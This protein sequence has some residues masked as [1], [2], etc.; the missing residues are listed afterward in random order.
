MMRVAVLG[1][2]GVGG[3]VAAALHR[4]GV[5]TTVVA[6]EATVTV[7]AERG[8][9]LSSLR[10]G[11]LVVHPAAT[12]RLD[13]DVDVLV[14]A[15]RARELEAALGRVSGAPG[16]VVPLLDGLDHVALLRERFGPRAVAATIAV[17]S[18]RV[19]PGVILQSSP[20]LRVELASDHP[21]PRPRMA[22]FRDV[23]R[24]AELPTR[25][26]D[27]E[28]CVLWSRLVYATAVACT[29]AAYDRPIGAVRDHPR[30]RLELEAAVDEGAAAANAE[31]AQLDPDAILR[32]LWQADPAT[33]S[34]LARDIAAGRDDELETIAG[35]VVRHAAAHDLATP[36]ISDLIAR[37]RSRALLA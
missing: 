10:L 22:A 7:I 27:T 9:R 1:P 32:T 4:A 11:E 20:S 34:T 29:T 5:P 16:L 19:T 26:G 25:L 21:S 18:E 6:R 35:A 33:S 37:I 13:D 30:A 23:L 31:G 28:A 2:G 8:L 12:S 24:T 3:L 36:T 14:V 15:T 17:Q